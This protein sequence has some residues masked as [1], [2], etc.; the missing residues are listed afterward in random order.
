MTPP[1]RPTASLAPVC[2]GCPCV[3]ISVWMRLARV[4]SRTAAS[5]ASAWAARPPSII[6]A[7]SGPGIA[8]TLHPAPWSSV[9]PPRSVVEIR[10]EACPALAEWGGSSTLPSAT[11]PACRRR[12][13]DNS[14]SVRLKADTTYEPSLRSTRGRGLVDRLMNARLTQREDIRPH[15]LGWAE[16]RPVRTSS[17]QFGRAQLAEERRLLLEQWSLQRHEGHEAPG[18]RVVQRRQAV[19]VHGVHI[20]AERR[21]LPDDLFEAL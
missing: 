2:S 15:T 20:D 12:R 14:V 11:T 5:R 18:L 10:E 4:T 8:I 7:P 3:L 6:S 19:L 16:D 21:E 13:R 9:A 17:H 1:L